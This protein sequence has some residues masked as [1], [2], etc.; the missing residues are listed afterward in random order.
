M[1]EQSDQYV[2][3]Q[4]LLPY[5]KGRNDHC[6]PKGYKSMNL[7]SLRVFMTMKTLIILAAKVCSGLIKGVYGNENTNNFSR[8]SMF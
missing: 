2:H 4:G 7:V 5:D 1:L 3:P 6:L 8:Q